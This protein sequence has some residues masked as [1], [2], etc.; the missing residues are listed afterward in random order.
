[1]CTLRI[2]VS[3]SPFMREATAGVFSQIDIPSN[4]TR[5]GYAYACSSFASLFSSAFSLLICIID[6]GAGGVAER[7]EVGDAISRIFTDV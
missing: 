6:G 7:V 5:C 1:M 3:V 4:L 2:C